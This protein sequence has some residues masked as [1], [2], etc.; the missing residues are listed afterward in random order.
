M[1]NDKEKQELKLRLKKISGQINGIDKMIDDGRY[2]VDILQ[3][4]TAARAALNQVS[5]LIL[6]SHTKSCV[7]TAIKEDR[8]EDAI[9]ELIDVVRK[10]SK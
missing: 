4:L 9:G 7:V 6:E 3:Q 2:C 8:A 10:F 5:L 1:L